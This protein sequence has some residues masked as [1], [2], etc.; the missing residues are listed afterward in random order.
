MAEMDIHGNIIR[1]ACPNLPNTHYTPPSSVTY[2]NSSPSWWNRLNNFVINIGNWLAEHTGDI[3]GGIMGLIGIG[4]VIGL[5]IWVFGVFSK[6]GV[7]IGILSIFGAVIMGYIA[8]AIIGIASYILGLILL[9]FRF[10]FWN[11]YSLL[12]GITIIA[13]FIIADLNTNFN[14]DNI[15]TTEQY[16]VPQTTKY[17]S[18]A[19]SVL[20]IRSAPNANSTVVGT[21][22][23][24]QVVD[25]YEIVNDFAK[26]EYN[27]NTAY[28]S[29]KYLKKRN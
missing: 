17:Y 9:I 22:R 18:T 14:N 28:V 3:T 6:D 26:I 2:T 29:L 21:L 10:F 23:P 16:A 5:V 25:V 12:F 24:N 4:V 19:R 11:I 20:N 7:F 13:F 27:R 8:F 15:A 1:R